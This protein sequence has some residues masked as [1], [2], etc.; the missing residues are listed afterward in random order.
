LFGFV[1]LLKEEETLG[2]VLHLLLGLAV[3]FVLVFASVSGCWL[4]V[5]DCTK[6]KQLFFGSTD[7]AP[8]SVC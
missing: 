5:A 1:F 7:K 8:I 2:F 3:Q 4:V 6:A